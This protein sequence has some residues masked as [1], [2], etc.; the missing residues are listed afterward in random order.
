[1]LPA[2]RGRGIGVWNNRNRRAP[3][4]RE[5][6]EIMHGYQNCSTH[7]YSTPFYNCSSLEL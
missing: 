7:F 3:S 2:G 6:G 4:E 5:S 1:M